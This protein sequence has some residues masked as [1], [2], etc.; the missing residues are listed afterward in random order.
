MERQT[1]AESLQLLVH[2]FRLPPPPQNPEAELDRASL[3]KLDQ[4]RLELRF[5]RRWVRQTEL[6]PLR[7]ELRRRALRGM[8]DAFLSACRRYARAMCSLGRYEG[9]VTS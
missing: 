8:A 9:T 4:H 5:H 6:R 1:F 7:A 3:Q 2:A